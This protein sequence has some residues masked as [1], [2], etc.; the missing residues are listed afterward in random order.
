MERKKAKLLEK[1]IVLEQSS[2]QIK[3][4]D[5]TLEDL[6]NSVPDNSLHKLEVRNCTLFK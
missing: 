6:I 4:L 3:N 1:G 5:K 2:S